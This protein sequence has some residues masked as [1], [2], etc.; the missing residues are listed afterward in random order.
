MNRTP[1]APRLARGGRSIHGAPLG[2]LMLEARVPRI[3]GAMGNGTTWPFPVLFRVVLEGARGLLPAFI[4]AA[5]ELADLG[6]GRALV[7]AH[8]EIGAIVLEC[9][10]MPPGAGCVH[11]RSGTM[12]QALFDRVMHAS[13]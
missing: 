11:L 9:T 7:A 8:P 13:R 1:I 6:A 3:P 4:A 10:N 5:R 12:L 2:I